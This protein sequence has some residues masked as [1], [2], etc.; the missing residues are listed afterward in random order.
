MRLGKKSVCVAVLAVL[1][2]LPKS[3]N[4]S[5]FLLLTH[6]MFVVHKIRFE[7][8]SDTC[9]FVAEIDLLFGK[10]Q[11]YIDQQNTP[12]AFD[13]G[14]TGS[15]LDENTLQA[16]SADK[17]F[18]DQ[19]PHDL[20]AYSD[21]HYLQKNDK[22][23]TIRDREG[24]LTR[25]LL[26]KLETRQPQ[27][28]AEQAAASL[29]TLQGHAAKTL[30]TPL[31]TF[32]DYQCYNHRPD[33]FCNRLRFENCLGLYYDIVNQ[34]EHQGYQAVVIN[35]NDHRFSL[36]PQTVRDIFKA[37]HQRHT[38]QA[39]Q[40]EVT[41]WC[42]VL[43]NRETLRAPLRNGA[44]FAVTLSDT[45]K[46][47]KTLAL[48]KCKRGL[49]VLFGP[50]ISPQTEG[51]LQIVTYHT[52]PDQGTTEN[53]PVF[54]TFTE[55]VAHNAEGDHDATYTGFSVSIHKAKD[56]E[57]FATAG[58]LYCRHQDNVPGH[59]NE[60]HLD[61]WDTPQGVVVQHLQKT[62]L[63]KIKKVISY[64]KLSHKRCDWYAPD[65]H[66]RRSSITG[67]PPYQEEDTVLRLPNDTHARYTLF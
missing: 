6:E 28:N 3:N 1:S 38:H 27:E 50:D 55:H 53:W 62:L 4:A 16:S 18:A 57:P 40:T 13:H 52:P 64:F 34:E 21:T 66:R 5:P 8:P 39:I 61:L 36:I 26:E 11:D 35:P 23:L 32:V 29:P 17:P 48:P 47:I 33:L 51:L 56:E 30:L 37:P 24:F 63:Q 59:I 12:N 67:A 20:F 41:T 25:I 44:L 45:L 65:E 9:H 19:T 22:T 54:F 60:T 15:L 46:Q 14:V 58:P 43:D 31:I 7:A 49:T 2:M 42:T 10:T